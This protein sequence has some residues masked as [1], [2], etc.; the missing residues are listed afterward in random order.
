MK[1]TSILLSIPLITAG[2]RAQQNHPGPRETGTIA[3]NETASPGYG[4]DRAALER[5]IVW[6]PL[7]E[8]QE[9][10]AY[11]EAKAMGERVVKKAD[12]QKVIDW[13]TGRSGLWTVTGYGEADVYAL[14]FSW[15]TCSFDVARVDDINLY[16]Q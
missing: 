10:C 4:N 9:A 16:F 15:G 5:Q 12:C 6:L 1:L 8:D 13:V 2:A 11:G 3:T 14:L 7:P